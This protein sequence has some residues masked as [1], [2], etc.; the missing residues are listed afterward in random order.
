VGEGDGMLRGA[1]TWLVGDETSLRIGF[2][3]FHGDADGLFGQFA[4]RD[5]ITL[6]LEHYY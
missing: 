4:D 3:A 5:R 2:D 1:L 6:S